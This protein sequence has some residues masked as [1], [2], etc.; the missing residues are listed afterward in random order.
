VFGSVMRRSHLLDS[1]ALVIKYASVPDW[2]TGLRDYVLIP[3]YAFLA[4][5][6]WPDKPIE[7]GVSFGRSYLGPAGDTSIGI[8]SRVN[9]TQ[10]LDV[11]ES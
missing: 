11:S 8:S 1:V 2:T 5:M 10:I 7:R 3:A 9:C 6:F 4:R